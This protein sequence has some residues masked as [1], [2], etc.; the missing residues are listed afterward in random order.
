MRAGIVATLLLLFTALSAQDIPTNSFK[1]RFSVSNHQVYLDWDAGVRDQYTVYRSTVSGGYYSV[2]AE[3]LTE[4]KYVDVPPTPA[5]RCQDYF[6]IVERSDE[7]S[8]RVE[9]RSNEV[10]VNVDK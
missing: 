7:S 6:Y 10:E 2:V 5:I 8:G 3:H 1:L 4:P 9:T